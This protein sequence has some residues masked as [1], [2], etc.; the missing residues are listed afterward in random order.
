MTKLFALSAALLL[1]STPSLAATTPTAA[2]PP[3]QVEQQVRCSIVFALVAQQQAR[4]TPGAD[5]FAPMAEPGKAFFVATGLRVIEQQVVTQA[6]LQD[7]YITR[8]AKVQAD[9]A[10]APQPA[11]ALDREMAQCLPLL[12]AAPT[13]PP[14]AGR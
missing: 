12:A 6:A 5:R 7:Y 3:P 8:V 11:A 13:A 2:T 14:A 9:L 1:S 4:K 10:A